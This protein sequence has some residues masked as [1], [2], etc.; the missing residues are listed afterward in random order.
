[1][2]I[3][4]VEHE[5]V[6]GDTMRMQ[7]I[8][9]NIL[10]N[11]AK[12][13]NPGGRIE[14]EISEKASD[15]YGYGCYEFVFRDNGIGMSREYLQKLFEPFSR[16]E[17]SRVS[18]TEGTGLGMTIARNIARRMNGDIAVESEL[19]KGTKFVVTLILKLADAEAQDTEKLA[20]LPC[21]WWTTIKARVRRPVLSLRTSA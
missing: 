6:I 5:R 18:K 8:F 21:W 9:M 7:Q 19:G 3:T 12:Y 2:H 17:D 1:M 10:G 11:A 16:A 14:M 20:E 13:T 4:S 15:T